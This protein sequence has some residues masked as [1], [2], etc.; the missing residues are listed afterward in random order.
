MLQLPLLGA[1]T[2]GLLAYSDLA[3]EFGRKLCAT[4]ST[5]DDEWRRPLSVQ[6]HELKACLPPT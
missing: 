5:M 3:S 1:V 2:P 4:H 6:Q